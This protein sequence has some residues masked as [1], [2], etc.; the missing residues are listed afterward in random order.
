MKFK[1][2]ATFKLKDV[3]VIIIITSLIV[4][5]STSLIVIKR[6][7]KNI[8]TKNSNNQNVN[9]FVSAYNT[10]INSYYEKIDEQEL[11]DSLIKDL[12]TY[13]GDP[14]TKYLN[15]E[16]TA[17]LLETLK[18]EYEGIGVRVTN[19]DDL[20]GILVVEVFDNSPA[21][22]AGIKAEDIIIK[23]NNQ[24]ILGKKDSEVVD[25]IKSSKNVS[26]TILRNKEEKTFKM[27][28]SSVDIP[29]VETKLYKN[30]NHKIGYIYIGAFAINTY[31]QF[32]IKLES[33]EKDNIDSLIIDVRSDTGGYLTT[34]KEIIELFLEKGK[35]IYSLKS[36]DIEETYKD[37]TLEKRDYPII[38]LT[39]EYSASASE[40][41]TAA[42]KE[43]YG[44]LSV[45]KTTYGK[46]KIQQTTSLKE[47]GMLKYTTATWL[48]PNGNC[49]DTKG[50]KPDY[51]IEYKLD[52]DMQLDKALEILS[53]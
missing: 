11:V 25:I 18:G 9:N 42:L 19:T 17:A 34:A 23:V 24:D 12:Y 26:V 27:E 8:N 6:Y 39:N 52:N 43:S 49:I 22:K 5:I 38:I 41:L 32:K 7:D 37:N 51:E 16:E 50:I 31:E 21:F 4:S 3:I 29:S 30:N 28:L 44:A 35:T 47:G 13:V 1:D 10:L 36:K 40:I 20:K 53:K 15:A 45:G 14:Y 2:K 46:G 48:T 33:L